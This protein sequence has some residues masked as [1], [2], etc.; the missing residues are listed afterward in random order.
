[1]CIC[2][3]MLC[4][5][6]KLTVYLKLIFSAIIKQFISIFF[7]LISLTFYY[8]TQLNL[9]KENKSPETMKYEKVRVYYIS[10]RFY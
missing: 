4:C 5:D 8:Y 3:G 6:Y 7:L 10:Y 1:M 9:I 2:V